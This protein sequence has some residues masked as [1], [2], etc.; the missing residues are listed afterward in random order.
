MEKN[1][2]MIVIAAVIAVCVMVAIVSLLRG[3]KEDKKPESLPEPPAVS[4][5]ILTTTTDYWDYLREQQATTTVT[6]ATDETGVSGDVTGTETG[7]VSGTEPGEGGEPAETVTGAE[8]T[9]T[10][11]SAVTEQTQSPQGQDDIPGFTIRVGQP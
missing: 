8:T 3:E 4:N 10:T 5:L 7:D 11:A 6:E 1:E 2:I 9:T